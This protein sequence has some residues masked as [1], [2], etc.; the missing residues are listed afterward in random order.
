MFEYTDTM[1]SSTDVLKTKQEMAILY[2]N[3]DYNSVH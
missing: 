3:N 1:D 2:D